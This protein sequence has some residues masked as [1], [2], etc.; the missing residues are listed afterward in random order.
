MQEFVGF[1][2]SCI[3]EIK[4]VS[5]CYVDRERSMQPIN[6]IRKVE[7]VFQSQIAKK[8]PLK[9]ILIS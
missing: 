6:S 5:G 2:D 8:E 3:K 4:Y 7:V 1:H 9:F